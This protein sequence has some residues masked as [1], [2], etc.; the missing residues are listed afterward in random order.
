MGQSNLTVGT[1]IAKN[2]NVYIFLHLNYF[3]FT[4]DILVTY[5]LLHMLSMWCVQNTTTSCQTDKLST[6]P[7]DNYV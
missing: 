3:V 4:N 5:F 2:L 6:R 7:I 1:C